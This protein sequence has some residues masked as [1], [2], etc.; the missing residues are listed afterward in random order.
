MEAA[1]IRRQWMELMGLALEEIEHYCDPAKYPMD[2]D[3]ERRDLEAMRR[4][5]ERKDCGRRE[6]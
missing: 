5:I 3:E 2:A 6:T 1:Q 4:I